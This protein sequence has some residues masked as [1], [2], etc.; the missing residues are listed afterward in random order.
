MMD[1][2][3][4]GE[5][6]RVESIRK[7]RLVKSRVYARAGVPE[8][9]MANVDEQCVEVHADP[10]ASAERY[11]SQAVVRPGEELAPRAFPSLRLALG[12]PFAA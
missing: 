2:G 12:A 7:D 11:R 9:W 1:A 3:I 5:D 10:D 8:Y 4:L 6:D